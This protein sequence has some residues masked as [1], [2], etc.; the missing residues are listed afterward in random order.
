MFEWRIIFSEARFALAI[1]KKKKMKLKHKTREEE[2]ENENGERGIVWQSLMTS[3][4]CLFLTMLL[5]DVLSAQRVGRAIAKAASD[6]EK[7]HTKQNT[8]KWKKQH[9]KHSFNKSLMC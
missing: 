1:L 6:E 3:L 7:P 4:L 9:N 2:S 8:G 5:F